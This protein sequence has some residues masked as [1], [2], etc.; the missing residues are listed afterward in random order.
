MKLSTR[1]RY[2]LR[3]MIK[4]AMSYGSR[5][6]QLGEISQTEGISEKYLGQI[7]IILKNSGLIES[8]RGAQGGFLLSRPPEKITVLEIAQTL[9]GDLSIVPCTETNSECER[10]TQCVS[11]SVWVELKNAIESVLIKYTLKDL[12]DM[13]TTKPSNMFYI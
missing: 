6:A 7:V 4:L 12:I 8:V 3:L 13:E 2:G 10:T 1:T 11:R 5:P 9:E